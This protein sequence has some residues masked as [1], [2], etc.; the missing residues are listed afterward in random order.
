M[1]IYFL[2][3]IT[4]S[5]LFNFSVN[6]QQSEIPPDIESLKKE[7]LQMRSDIDLVQVNIGKSHQRFKVGIAAAT[8]GY[9][10][11]IAGGLMLGRENDQL[12]QAL[13]VAGGAIGLTGTVLL[14]DAFK[15]LGRAG[16]DKHKKMPVKLG[17]SITP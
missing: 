3:L 8:L 7:I 5:F 13:L 14:V 2:S 16:A 6:A 12:G 15:F 11:T 1:R 4:L 10:V 17:T 9:S